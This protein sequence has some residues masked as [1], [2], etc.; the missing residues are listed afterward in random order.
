MQARARALAAFAKHPHTHTRARAHTHAR[1]HA[2]TKTST[3]VD[4][5]HAHK[6]KHKHSRACAGAH[7]MRNSVDGG[8]EL[9]ELLVPQLLGEHLL[10]VDAH[11]LLR[12]HAA[13]A[14]RGVRD[15]AARKL[16]NE[17]LVA[18]ATVAVRV[19][20]AEDQVELPGRDRNVPHV[21]GAVDLIARQA[22][23]AVEVDVLEGLVHVAEAAVQKNPYIVNLHTRSTKKF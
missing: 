5:Q 1:T 9:G 22:A 23:G 12:L 14:H 7:T 3:R 2:H 8:L 16:V 18:H 19:A 10:R 21:E 13:L 15:G 11:R 20:V 4:R 6:H 17:L